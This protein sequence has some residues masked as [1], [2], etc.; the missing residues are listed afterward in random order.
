MLSMISYWLVPDARHRAVFDGLI[1]S[2]AAR[3][4]AP[5]F[6]PHVTIYA[7]LGGEV[8][9]P[10]DVVETAVRGL[11][12]LTLRPTG[13]ETSAEFTKTLFVA[14][15]P[16][17]ALSRLSADLR[18]LSARPADYALAPHLSL[19]YR[20]MAEAER[21]VLAA[22]IEVP[23]ETVVF[24]RVTAIYAPARTAARADVESWQ[25]AYTRTLR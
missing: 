20:A 22:S 19:M 5:A 16:S 25:V 11:G 21:A 7:G 18:R 23:H 17:E 14:F 1:A 24:D 4:D 10:G 3:Y 15:H 2:L 9:A 8:D 13:V 6:E 12:P